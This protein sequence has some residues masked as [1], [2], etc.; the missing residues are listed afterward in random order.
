MPNNDIYK[1]L[2]ELDNNFICVNNETFETKTKGLFAIGDC[3][4]KINRQ[5]IAATSDGSTSAF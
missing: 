1:D 5:L 4:K 3:I 2:F